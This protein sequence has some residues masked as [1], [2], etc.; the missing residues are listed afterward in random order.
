[1]EPTIDSVSVVATWDGFIH[2]DDTWFIAVYG[3]G[4]IGWYGPVSFEIGRY[5]ESV[6]AEAVIGESIIDHYSLFAAV[7]SA[8]EAD[9]TDE[10]AS[11]AVGT[12]DCAAWDLHG[13]IVGAPVSHLISSFPRTTVPLYASWLGL[14]LSVPTSITTVEEI[15]RAGWQFTKWGLRRRGE[16]DPCSEATMLCATVKL[17]TEVL[18]NAAAFDAVCTWD[19]TLAEL[20]IDRLE[21]EGLLWLEDLLPADD[22]TTYQPLATKAPLALGERLLLHADESAFLRLK[23]RALTIDVVAC[24][25]LTR[26]IDLVAA[27]DAHGIEVYPHGRSF[28][29]GLHLAAAFPD[30]VQAVEYRLEW[31][32][33]RLRRFVSAPLPTPDGIIIPSL[34]GLGTTPR[35]VHG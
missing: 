1:M 15:G 20:V 3:G 19:R 27:A 23:P 16:T 30:T 18:G 34:P 4:H 8:A 24:G 12:L 32:P 5:V 2:G 25:G 14:D 17:V 6:L 9:G 11:W 7:R 26:A 21:V 35:F 10:I 31:E 29:P 28:F 33:R 22:L 13:Q